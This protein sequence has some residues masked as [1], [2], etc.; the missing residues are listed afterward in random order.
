MTTNDSIIREPSAAA[1]VAV[2]KLGVLCSFAIAASAGFALTVTMFVESFH[3]ARVAVVMA[4]LI[5]FQLMR[6]QRIFVSREIVLYAVFCFYML[7]QLLWVPDLRLAM[8]TMVPATSCLL[9][10]ILFGSLIAYHD[11]R[12]VLAG[13]LSGFLLGA[14]VYSFTTGFPFAYP[15][16]FSYNAIASMYLFGLIAALLFGCFSRSHVLILLAAFVILVHIVATTSIKNNLGILLGVMGSSLIYFRES[17]AILRKHATALITFAGL[18]VYILATNPVL[19]DVLR[20]GSDR[21]IVGLRVL[22]AREDIPG[23]G[24]M[25]H[26]SEWQAEGLS[27]WIHNPVFGHGP[28][29]FRSQFGITSHST[30][31]DILYNS[32]LIGFVLFYLIFASI[33]WRLYT[34]RHENQGNLLLL[35]LAALICYFFV[36]LSGVLHYS[37]SFAA[38]LAISAGLLRQRSLRV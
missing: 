27:G 15:P 31:V 2:R 4:I 19:M 12:I 23:Y 9:T 3:S 30:P 33:A 37:S 28:E 38:I 16:G 34:V 21:V 35:L 26:R 11:V 29:A 18:L 14:A 25:A 22:Q 13:I 32:G 6:F 24:S 1:V 17:A 36:S 8:N 7:I 10:M 5:L 20:R